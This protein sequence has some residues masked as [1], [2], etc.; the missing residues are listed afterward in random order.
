MAGNEL[1]TEINKT[2]TKRTIQRINKTKSQFF[3][4]FNK[5]DKS[6]S[7][8]RDRDRRSKIDKSETKRGIQ[9]Q[10][11]KKS[12][13]SLGHTSKTCTPQNWKI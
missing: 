6:L 11:K 13:E 1:R 5:I 10:T 7:K 12:K 3:E 9:H 2:E 8:L 4:R